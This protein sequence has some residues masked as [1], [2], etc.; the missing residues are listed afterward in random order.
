MR[1]PRVARSGTRHLASRPLPDS[2]GKRPEG[3]QT[4]GPCRALSRRGC[5][6][7]K[8]PIGTPEA[9]AE[10]ARVKGLGE[11]R[12]TKVCG[13]SAIGIPVIAQQPSWAAHGWRPEHFRS[14]GPGSRSLRP[15]GRGR[16]VIICFSSRCVPGE[17]TEG[18]RDPGFALC[19]P[20]IGGC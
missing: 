9:Q 17:A 10:L 5:F 1:K 13:H 19:K 12:L 20:Q 15:L 7:G 14:M 11:F 18:Y 16:E 2:P 4:R 8:L 3:A 6:H